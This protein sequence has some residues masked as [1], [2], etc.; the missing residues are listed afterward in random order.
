MTA[1]GPGETF[2]IA[3]SLKSKHF[4]LNYTFKIGIIIDE[5]ENIFNSQILTGHLKWTKK[6][7]I[8]F[9]KKKSL[10]QNV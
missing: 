3:I 8:I 7:N 6:S 1:N 2:V 9:N 5:E 4:I 10:H